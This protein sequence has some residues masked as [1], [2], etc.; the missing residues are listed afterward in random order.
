MIHLKTGKDQKILPIAAAVEDDVVAPP[1]NAVEENAE[2]EADEIPPN[3]EE[4]RN[5]EDLQALIRLHQLQAEN[6]RQ[7]MNL[8]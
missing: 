1:Q 8:F 3:N 5:Q 6:L 2:A 7:L 4:G